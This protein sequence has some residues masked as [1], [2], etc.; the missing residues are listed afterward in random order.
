MNKKMLP[1]TIA[2]G[3]MA[4]AGTAYAQTTTS[5]T[6]TEPSSAQTQTQSAPAAS[7][8]RISGLK[9]KGGFGKGTSWNNT[10]LLSLLGLDADGLKTELQAGKSL[11]EIAAAKGVTDQA[12]IDLLVKQET[13]RLDQAVTD[14]K[15]TQPQAD[16]RK[17]QLSTQIA[18]KI[19][20]QGAG[21]DKG[22]GGKGG[23]GGFHGMSEAAGV[24]GM[25]E[26][27]VLDG[28]KAG[29]S[30]SEI[31]AEKGVDKQKL[32]DALLQKEEE[33]IKTF[34]D[35]KRT[36]PAASPYTGTSSS[37]AAPQA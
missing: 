5:T 8:D 26:Q 27:E 33:R 6:G 34:V 19:K 15:L 29:K 23:R 30:L 17:A 37:T 36:A 13:A 20:Q 25:T 24:L 2:I 22:R 10:E 32:I 14:G 4:I 28:L 11:S 12:V 35:H 7:A 31:A 3:L 9:G 16:E 21:F 18:E 1:L